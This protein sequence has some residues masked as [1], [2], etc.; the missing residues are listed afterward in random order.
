[1]TTPESDGSNAPEQA[2]G[3][4]AGKNT[5]QVEAMLRPGLRIDP[6][7]LPQTVD[8]SA[9]PLASA[10]FCIIG[11]AAALTG[12]AVLVGS[13]F[14]DRVTLV[15]A[16]S[17]LVLGLPTAYVGFAAWRDKSCIT[18]GKSGVVIEERVRK[19]MQKWQAPY[20]AFEGV[21]IRS[22]KVTWKMPDAKSDMGA[23]WGAF[24]GRRGPTVPPPPRT[25]QIVELVHG[26]ALRT[27]PLRV[28]EGDKPDRT[29]WVRM[30]LAF[31]VPALELSH[32]QIV[33]RT[34]E[35]A[36]AAAAAVDE[37]P[38]SARVPDVGNS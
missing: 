16:I 30:A 4:S 8:F 24:G 20:S 29:Y 28:A 38:E 23:F 35:E 15:L 36:V 12:L 26:D 22:E 2:A 11:L 33:S 19:G 9:S 13:G 10:A 7:R 5:W 6:E 37:L 34:A 17:M 25:F 31:G 3:V 21:L 1:M 32:G 27:L 14:S 18:F